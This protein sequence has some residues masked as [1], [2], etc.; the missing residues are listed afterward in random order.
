MFVFFA[1]LVSPSDSCRNNMFQLILPK[2]E[3]TYLNLI[4]FQFHFA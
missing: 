2:V 4:V 1:Y 3:E